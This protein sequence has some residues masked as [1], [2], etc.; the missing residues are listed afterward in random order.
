MVQINVPNVIT[1]GLIALL[2]VGAAKFLASK[3]G[4]GTGLL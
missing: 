1:I 3:T 4:F 2:F